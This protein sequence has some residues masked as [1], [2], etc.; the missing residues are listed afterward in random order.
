MERRSRL[1]G[2]QT[3]YVGE[4]GPARRHKADNWLLVIGAL[5]MIIGLVVVYS[6]SPALSASQNTSQGYFVTKQLIDIILG[7]G[8]FLLASSL[9][10]NT[11]L[12]AA[13]PLAIAAIAGSV[14][15]M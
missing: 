6:I 2:G 3:R 9:P 14:L 4:S 8:T 10:L 1:R 7:I 12:K 5:L 11:W 13:K 15:V